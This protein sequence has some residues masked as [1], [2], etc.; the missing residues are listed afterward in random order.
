MK[1]LIYKILV[2][3]WDK[4]LIGL[5]FLAL[6]FINIP[7]PDHFL[8]GWDNLQ[9][10]LSPLL[11]IKRA[12][13]S[14]WQQ[15]Q[16]FGLI[17]GMAHGADLI[18]SIAIYI[19]SLILP[20]YLIRYTFI[21][22]ML[23]LGALGMGR[24]FDS[25]LFLP[26]TSR[27]ES[28]L[29]SISYMLNF[30]TIQLFFLP[31]ESFC[32]FFAALPFLVISYSNLLHRP[33]KKTLTTFVIIQLLATPS[34]VSQQLFVVYLIVLTCFSV[35]SKKLFVLKRIFLIFIL[36]FS[37]NSFWILPQIYFLKNNYDVVKINQMNTISTSDIF[38]QNKD[39]GTVN[40]LM[41]QN[42]FFIDLT[43]KDGSMIFDGWEVF[44]NSDLAKVSIILFDIFVLVGIFTLKSKRKGQLYLLT[45][46]FL[47][48]MLS[49]T[50]GFGWIN[51]V[52]RSIPFINQVF[53]SPFTKFGIIGSFLMSI[54]LVSGFR[55]IFS[56]YVL[57]FSTKKKSK[58]LLTMSVFLV[59]YLLLYQSVY[60]YSGSLYSS[61]MKVRIPPQY[62]SVGK[63]L[64]DQDPTSRVAIFPE[65]S[66]WGWQSNDWGYLGSGFLWYLIPQ[67]V[68]S[69]TFDVWSTTSESYYHQL[70]DVLIKQD[71]EK[72]EKLLE[73]YDVR[74]LLYDESLQS[75]N[76]PS[77]AP[78]TQ[79]SKYMLD[80]CKRCRVVFGQNKLILYEYLPHRTSK[81]FISSSIISA[82]K[83]SFDST[84][85]S[86]EITEYI[87]S[88]ENE[89]PNQVFPFASL[90]SHR[91]DTRTDFTISQSPNHFILSSKKQNLIPDPTYHFASQTYNAQILN[92]GIPKH[93]ALTTQID[94][95]K[96]KIELK[97]PKITLFD[98]PFSTLTPI[99]CDPKSKISYDWKE[100]DAFQ[101]LDVTGKG[102]VCLT[103]HLPNLPLKHTYLLDIET[104]NIAGEEIYLYVVD[105]TQQ[106]AIVESKLSKQNK[107]FF[108]PPGKSDSLG[109]DISVRIKSFD[110]TP[111]SKL[112][113]NIKIYLFPS[114]VISKS[115][116]SKSKDLIH[117]PIS[118]ISPFTIRSNFHTTS[119]VLPDSAHFVYYLQG[120]ESGFG[121]YETSNILSQMFPVLFGK[122]IP[123]HHNYLGWANTWQIPD[124]VKK[125]SVLTIYYWPQYLQYLGL[126][127]GG[128]VILISYKK[129]RT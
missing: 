24:L 49:A 42:S 51:E 52:F 57:L 15:Y 34:F 17:A 33:N 83:I 87:S 82:Q 22:S 75:L 111:S 69:R 16:S 117:D 124:N 90:L 39:R 112:L 121:L 56:K 129:I 36:I 85:A 89:V 73:K 31:F 80:H 81:K 105:N 64:S 3:Y 43:G 45:A 26:K 7:A 58:I 4:L 53:R 40:D 79:S 96:E 11:G 61:Q 103:A 91:P 107:L 108:T 99:K 76:S 27:V 66:F 29:G 86:P 10:D 102:S 67:P 116:L 35:I 113:G 8:S 37:L 123:N 71:V 118:Y 127:F 60:I 122:N 78:I 63:Y 19:L 59:I 94:A 13:W 18:R 114:E 50:Y 74:Y 125:N 41:N 109:M 1:H 23:F 14:V 77:I 126:I 92:D 95:N 2:R 32:I 110:K 115:F 62:L 100:Q 55:Y 46:I 44:R 97:I 9:T 119:F 84:F 88:K 106:Q 25:G 93:Y 120:F 70:R 72:F 5:C 104:Q 128:V 38:Y 68:I 30:Y 98:L 48:V 101:K 28:F 47:V 6:Y 20:D 12:W 21:T 54:Y 65:I